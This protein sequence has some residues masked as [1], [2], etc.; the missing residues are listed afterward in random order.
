MHFH[1]VSQSLKPDDEPKE[2]FIRIQVDLMY[3]LDT[4]VC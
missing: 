3:E 4:I 2:E 1:G